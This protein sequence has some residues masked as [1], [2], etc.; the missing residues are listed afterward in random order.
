M[1]RARTSP[2]STL[3]G[4]PC[5]TIAFSSFWPFLG[6]NRS[7]AQKSEGQIRS[8]WQQGMNLSF[9]TTYDCIKDISETNFTEDLKRVNIPGLVPHEE[10]PGCSYPGCRA[11]IS[12]APASR[13]AQNLPGRL[14]RNLQYQH[15]RSKQAPARL[16]TVL[17]MAWK[18]L[19]CCNIPTF[20][21]TRQLQSE[22]FPLENS[23][24][25][26]ANNCMVLFDELE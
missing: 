16:S 21:Y 5:T 6:F 22:A 26:F 19:V 7:G 1:Q 23:C 11:Q 2:F 12:E 13:K 25:D 24:G 17:K 18:E 15:W 4:R 10:W 20:L 9:K 3:L 14:S 8:W